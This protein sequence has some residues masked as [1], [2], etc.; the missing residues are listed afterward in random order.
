MP[1][2]QSGSGMDMDQTESAV[3]AVG[4]AGLKQSGG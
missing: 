2:P 3:K 1:L 4:Q